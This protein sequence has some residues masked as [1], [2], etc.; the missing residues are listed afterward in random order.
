MHKNKTMKYLQM[1]NA[2]L[3][4]LIFTAIFVITGCKKTDIA[5]Y[6]GTY[7]GTLTSTNFIKEDVQLTFTSEES[8]KESLFLY[9]I[10][11][12]NTSKGQYSAN[13]EI[14]LKII[15]IINQDITADVIS[16]TSAVF[17]F[18]EEEV[19]MDMKYNIA[20]VTNTVNVRY[21]GNK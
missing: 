4:T 19:T 9:G 5:K 13:D 6:T 17:V 8:H 10:A 12:T 3:L 1:K 18:E 7:T 20:G 21:I 15:H 2:L 14:V 16:N 11:L